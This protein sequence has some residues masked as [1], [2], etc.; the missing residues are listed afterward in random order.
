M[1]ADIRNMQQ[2]MEKFPRNKHCKVQL[3]E[4]IERRKKCLKYLRKWDYK[5]FEWLLE[6]LDLI[7]RPP[8]R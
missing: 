5:R 7:Y 2:V 4:L 3:K 8:P 6:K 1:T